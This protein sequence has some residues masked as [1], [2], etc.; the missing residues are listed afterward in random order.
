MKVVFLGTGAGMP[1][2]LRNVSGTVLDLSQ[3]N[4]TH[5]LFDCG[6]ATQHQILYT[7]IKPRKIEKIFISHLHGDHIFGLPGLLGSRSHQN[8]ETKVCIYG[9]KGLEEFIYTAFKVS[10]TKLTYELQIYVVEEGVIFEDEHLIVKAKRMQHGMLCFGYSILQKDLPGALQV[11]RLKAMGIQP[12]PI[13]QEIKQGKQITLPNG[14][15]I[16]GTDFIGAPKKGKKLT[17]ITDTHAISQSIQF[18][19]G[20]DLLIHEGTF[21][22]A[23]ALQAE[24]YFHS[25]VSQAAQIAKEAKVKQLILTHISSRYQ[26]KDWLT[27]LEEATCIFPNTVMAEDWSEWVF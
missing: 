9:P 8:G 21:S 11:E 16:C 7:S 17:F 15:V 12:G 22:Q 14:H 27:L 20:S 2:K 24:Q 6:E 26:K 5:W 19:Q 3:E 4:G 1:S 18:A 25:T 13:Y 23:E 10:Q